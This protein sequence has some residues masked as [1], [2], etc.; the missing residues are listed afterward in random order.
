MKQVVQNRK[1]GRVAVVDVPVPALQRGRVLVR[2][3]ASLISSGTERAAVEQA[4][5]SLLQQAR[6]RPD[7]VRSV[8]DKA[9]TE[10]LLQT[11]EAVRD[12]LAASQALGYSA[13]G[14]VVEVGHDVPEFRVGDR[15]AC[16]GLGFASHAEAISVPKHLCVHLPENVDFEAGAFG[17]LGAI[18][19]QGVRLAEPTLGE[20]FVVIGLGLVG[21]LTVQLLKAN[22]CRVFGIDLD[23]NRI[24]LARELG[25]EAGCLAN[26][27][28]AQAV[29]SWTS[30]RGA[31]AV[32]ITAASD[33]NQPIELAGEISR[34]KGRVV[35]VG[36]TGLQIP[37]QTFYNRELALK[38]SMSYGPGRYD[39]EYEE[40]GQDYPFGYVRWTEQRN[41]EAF[42]QLISER[43]VNVDRLVTHR[44]PVAEAERAYD[45][46]GGSLHEPH[47]GVLLEYDP[48][49]EPER[50]VDL[51]GHSTAPQKSEVRVRIGVI[52]AG[53]Y[54][55]AM[56]LP[57][58]QS[59]GAEFHSIAT[60]SG[61]SAHDVGNKFGFARAVSDA[62]A[63][64]ND[65][66]VNL[67]VIG[68][69]N[70]LHAE[71]ARRALERGHHVFVEKPLALSDEDLDRLLEVAAK[72]N[73]RLVVGF[74][75]RFS[76][77]AVNAKDFYAGRRA[78]LSF[79]Y[80]VNAGR[81][82]KGHWT[83]DPREGGGRIVGEVCHFIDLLQY[84]T[85][86]RP[87]SVFA[88]TI[89]SGNQELVDD[90]SVLITVRFA[91]GS[92]ACI[93][94]L[95]E[96]DKTLP[97]E[98]VEIFGDGKVF[99]LDDFRTA[100]LYRKGRE[101]KLKLR[102][103]DKGQAGEVKAVCRMVLEG[104]PP[105]IA[106]QELAATTRATFRILDSLRTGQPQKVESDK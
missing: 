3:V 76:P 26:D 98:R 37:R 83:Q 80:R 96:G 47:L 93:A 20:S 56:L 94:Y 13:S 24:N 41:I 70:D 86:A 42:L 18:A 63:V 23:P 57:Q 38:I 106:L 54:L 90:D 97:K 39:P 77:L 50:V 44:F 87:V 19:L 59:A 35:V 89:A 49:N 67:V 46:I 36:S 11:F 58:F 22:G 75:R 85:E 25:A 8:V 31:D 32:L 73:G 68:T 95:A 12:K 14:T 34:V 62:D 55:R 61:V 78:P 81:V 28:A 43:R 71:L 5:K 72:A 15:V 21:Q 30:G 6:D 103:Q 52:G 100:R 101:E 4:R 16:A 88:Q 104:G 64:I 102:K 82:P 1:T 48:E 105:P 65:P 66:Q 17:T 10:G 40:R 9:R 29:N 84:W 69:R 51:N 79:V 91:D 99:V 45:V 27:D 74:N 92:T 7:L 53:D 33:S 2:T 60:A